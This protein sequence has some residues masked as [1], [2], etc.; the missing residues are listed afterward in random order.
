[1]RWR[2]YVN[3]NKCNFMTMSLFFLGF[4]VS[5]DGIHVDKEKVK[6]I[7]VWRRPHTDILHGLATLYKYFICNFSSIV[8][9]L[10][11][12]MKKWRFQW[13]PEQE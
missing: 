9:S 10:T 4:V 3:L 13:D 11:N 8:A 2:E 1:M 5:T 12:C 6:A 7:Q